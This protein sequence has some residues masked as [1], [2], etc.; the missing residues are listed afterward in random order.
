MKFVELSESREWKR[1]RKEDVWILLEALRVRCRHHPR[2]TRDLNFGDVEMNVNGLLP[3]IDIDQ[4][5]NEMEIQREGKGKT[6]A[7]KQG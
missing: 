1:W 3:H 2:N 5:D 7:Q 6:R 4:R